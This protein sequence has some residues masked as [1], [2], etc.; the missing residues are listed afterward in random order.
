MKK[1]MN[2]VEVMLAESLRVFGAAHR[3]LVEVSTEP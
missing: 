3:D 1:L 2:S